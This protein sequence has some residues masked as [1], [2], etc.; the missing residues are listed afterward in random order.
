MVPSE[1]GIAPV[2][3]DTAP[4]AASAAPVV[5]AMVVPLR[6]GNRLRTERPS[7]GNDTEPGDPKRG[8]HAGA[9]GSGRISDPGVG[10]LSADE[11]TPRRRRS[12]AIRWFAPRLRPLQ[13]HGDA[14][15]KRVGTSRE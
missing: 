14:E 12:S 10:W 15:P 1:P 2:A 9:T 3:T 6:P 11:S 5:T 13:V 8:Q 7:S 4:T